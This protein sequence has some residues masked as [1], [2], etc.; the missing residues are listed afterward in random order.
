MTSLI[1]KAIL[2]VERFINDPMVCLPNEIFYF[3]SKLTPLVNVDLLIK[4]ELNETLLTWRHDQFYGP[5]W[6]LPGGIIR[7]RENFS[8]RVKKVAMLELGAE[9]Y[10]DEHPIAIRE[11]FAKK[12]D[13]RGHFISLLIPC[14]LITPLNGNQYIKGEPEHGQWAW[15]KVAPNNLLEQQQTFIKFINSNEH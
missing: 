11:L 6:H 3:I 5:A 13:V 4:N 12:R 9:V 2:E 10:N 14:K 7:F 1:Q 15:H 8:T